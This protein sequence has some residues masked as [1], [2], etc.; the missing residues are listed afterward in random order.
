MVVVWGFA[1]EATSGRGAG[2]PLL[3]GGTDDRRVEFSDL[4]GGG[5]ALPGISDTLNEYWLC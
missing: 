1:V 3:P 2:L 5:E 4:P